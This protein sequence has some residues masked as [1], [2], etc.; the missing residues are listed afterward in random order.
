MLIL[1]AT[2]LPMPNYLPRGIHEPPKDVHTPSLVLLAR[3][4]GDH[5]HDSGGNLV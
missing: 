3:N 1:L 2:T 4:H 5:V